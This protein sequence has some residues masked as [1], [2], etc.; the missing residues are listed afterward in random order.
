MGGRADPGKQSPLRLAINQQSGPPRPNPPPQALAPGRAQARPG[1]ESEGLKSVDQAEPGARARRGPA[2]PSSPAPA[3]SGSGSRTT[4]LLPVRSRRAGQ[5]PTSG[6]RSRSGPK[7]PASH[8]SRRRWSSRRPTTRRWSRPNM[9][10]SPSGRPRRRG[11]QVRPGGPSLP[12]PWKSRE[13]ARRRS[14][15][16]AN[17]RT[18]RSTTD[19][20]S[21]TDPA[22]RSPRPSPGRQRRPPI[23]PRLA[24]LRRT[25]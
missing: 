17:R 7:P 16:S 4:K 19:R 9:L 15:P 5:S 13:A 25:G 10:R 8:G 24:A 2:C 6:I 3:L 21:W 11:R 23:A 22:G 14:H 1:W 20:T 12:G 18:P